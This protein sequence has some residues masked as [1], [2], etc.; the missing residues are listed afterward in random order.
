MVIDRASFPG[1][2]AKTPDGSI[3]PTARSSDAV[4]KEYTAFAIADLTQ[5]I[6][7]AVRLSDD[8]LVTRL[9]AVLRRIEAIDRITSGSPLD[10]H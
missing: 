7:E 3:T 10:R 9:D 5:L 1:N 2:S 6:V 8:A 4:L